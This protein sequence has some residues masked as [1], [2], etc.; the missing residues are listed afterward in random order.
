MAVISMRARKKSQNT[1]NQH[2]PIEYVV[3]VYSADGRIV[4]E[5]LINAVK[6]QIADIEGA[7]AFARKTPAISRF[8]TS[9]VI[10]SCEVSDSLEQV[11]IAV[12]ANDEN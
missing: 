11:H 5:C 4:S 7:E 6:H 10:V 12:A 2:C 9:I 8:G 3:Q 1:S